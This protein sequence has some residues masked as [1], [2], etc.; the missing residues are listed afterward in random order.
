MPA[1][2]SAL[3]STPCCGHLRGPLPGHSPTKT[4]AT[5]SPGTHIPGLRGDPAELQDVL[6]P[7]AC[8]QDLQVQG[9]D[10]GRESGGVGMVG[11]DQG[12]FSLC[13]I[14]PSSRLLK[15]SFGSRKEERTHS[16]ELFITVGN[17]AIY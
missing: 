4:R 12:Q 17:L 11:G 6:S 10:G 16:L 13:D 1:Q 9:T 8:T 7:P 5:P 14:L 2:S 3:L 15:R